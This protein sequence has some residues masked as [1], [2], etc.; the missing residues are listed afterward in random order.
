MSKTTKAI[1]IIA[2]NTQWVDGK[3]EWD[4]WE[5]ACQHNGCKVEK[6]YE[7]LRI[8]CNEFR[9][10]VFNK[11]K[12]D[13]N[14]Q[15]L[16]TITSKIPD[17]NI[18]EIYIHEYH[19]TFE[20]LPLNNITK[21]VYTSSEEDKDKTKFEKIKKLIKLLET[22]HAE[23]CK[24]VT[25][26]KEVF[27]SAQKK[28]DIARLFRELHLIFLSLVIDIKGVE[29]CKR[30]K[31]S[32]IKEYIKEVKGDKDERSNLIL[33]KIKAIRNELNDY[34]AQSR[35]S[36]ESLINIEV[37]DL[38]NTMEQSNTNNFI[39]NLTDYFQSNYNKTLEKYCQ[40]LLNISMNI[41]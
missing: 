36:M 37:D 1:V 40:D 33:D 23:F 18:D 11:N 3:G 21:G 32:G 30:N 22:D 14:E 10:I 15:I 2:S 35:E 19:E 26:L 28:I 16:N 8:D 24:E 4:A 34:K 27:S 12:I 20:D 29:I 5:K 17:I 7:F 41:K 13:I 31:I 39:E 38:K 6:N 25:Q 9:V